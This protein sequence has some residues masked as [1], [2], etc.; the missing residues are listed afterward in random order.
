MSKKVFPIKSETACPLKW[1]WSTILFNNG[2]SSG[3]HRTKKYTIDPNNFDQFNNLP[4]KL[5]QRQKMLNGEWADDGCQYCQRIEQAGGD[6]DRTAALRDQNPF[7]VPPE[8]DTDS[9]A[10]SVTPTILEVYFKNTCNM[11]CLYCSEL[12]SS[13]WAEENKKFQIISD[14]VS[15]NPNYQKMVDGLWQYLIKDDRYLIIKR[16]H[17]LGGEPFL[18]KE[19]ED[20]ISFWSN[21]PNPDLTFSIISNLNIPHK[22]FKKY[23]DQFEELISSN[24][25]WRLQLTASLDAWG[26][27]QEY[28]RFGLDLSQWEENFNYLLD[29]NWIDVSIN[30]TVSALTIKQMPD[31]FHKINK[32]GA[33]TNILHSFNFTGTE[34]DPHHFGAGFFDKDFDDMISITNN[35]DTANRLLSLKKSVSSKEFNLEKINNLKLY[36]DQLDLRRNTDWKTTFPWLAN[37]N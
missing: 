29:K 7:L 17:I 27:E 2:T 10:L 28:T 21:H 26:K 25:I 37:I 20:S 1:T 14:R 6:S 30:S 16:Y 22:I 31:M 12:H 13:S 34:D 35:L 32:W 15:Q 3:C 11:K 5:I 36:L 18:V 19:L 4:E 9:T 23:I 33:K 8:L 24:K